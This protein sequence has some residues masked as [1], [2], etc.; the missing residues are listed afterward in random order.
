[1]A[2]NENLT[3]RAQN[4]RIDPLTQE[5]VPMQPFSKPLTPVALAAV[6]LFG[7]LS[8]AF[9]AEQPLPPDEAFKLK[10]AF[11]SADTVVA[12]IVP[13]S[14]H[15]L[16][17]SKTRFALKN[18]SGVLIRQVS[19]PAGEMKNDPFF[20]LIEIYKTPVRAEIALDRAPKAQGFTLFASY[21]GC[22]EKIGVCYPP[23]E[24]TVEMKFPK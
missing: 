7:V 8:A 15:Y 4:P 21:Q 18:S 19:L 3:N 5:Y 10:V 20:G 13:A 22:N 9:A 2:G 24:K 1:M 23:I 11:R 14:N 17:K 6:L 12:E 16:Y